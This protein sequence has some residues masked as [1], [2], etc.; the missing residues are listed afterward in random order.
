MDHI[1]SEGQSCAKVSARAGP[2]SKV[3]HRLNLGRGSHWE[4][5]TVENYHG[6]REFEMLL[7]FFIEDPNSRNP[8]SR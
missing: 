3:E 4:R 5:S 8:R 1:L 6:N 7:K 2:K